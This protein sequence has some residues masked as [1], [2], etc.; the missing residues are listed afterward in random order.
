M[1]GKDGK[2]DAM[3]KFNTYYLGC[4]V[5]VLCSPTAKRQKHALVCIIG[6]T[7][8]QMEFTQLGY[9]Y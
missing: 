1:G 7:I 5:E 4:F 8:A 6:K 9:C 3:I 2:Q